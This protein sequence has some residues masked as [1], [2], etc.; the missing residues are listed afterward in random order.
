MRK[1]I[2]NL[3]QEEFRDILDKKA[4]LDINV[5]LISLQI[6]DLK[7]KFWN[8]VRD[9]LKE[10]NIEINRDKYALFID[11]DKLFE[12]DKD[13]VSMIIQSTMF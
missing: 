9:R 6:D 8:E 7:S 2:V 4:E 11:N 10:Q 1:E 13:E 3:T 12:I 5:T